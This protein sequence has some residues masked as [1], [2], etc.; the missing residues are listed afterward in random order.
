[1]IVTSQKHFIG[2]DRTLR[3]DPANHTDLQI[4][5]HREEITDNLRG[6]TDFNNN[7]EGRRP[8]ART[9]RPPADREGSVD[10]QSVGG[11]AP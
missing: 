2:S 1:M 8:G 5:Q 11:A 9:T 4:S 6:F 7:L 3:G 10:V